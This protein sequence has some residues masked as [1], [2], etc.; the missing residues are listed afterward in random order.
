MSLGA[1]HTLSGLKYRISSYTCYRKLTHTRKLT[2]L[3]PGG[4]ITKVNSRGRAQS[5]TPSDEGGVTLS[6]PSYH[7]H[8]SSLALYL[9]AS[10][11]RRLPQGPPFLALRYMPPWYHAQ[12]PGLRSVAQMACPSHVTGCSAILVHQYR[13]AT[14]S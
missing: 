14:L 7:E 2:I 4:G 10:R 5:S 1:L 8:M 3:S 12:A 11:N 9:K 6:L 13:Q